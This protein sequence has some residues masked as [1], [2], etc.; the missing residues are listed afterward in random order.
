MPNPITPDALKAMRRDNGWSQ[1][2]LAMALCDVPPDQ[3]DT[4]RSIF[5]AVALVRRWESG[6]QTPGNAYRRQLAK[7]AGDHSMFDQE[8]DR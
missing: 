5:S 4:Y 2:D 1:L 3:W 7:L 8:T 6:T